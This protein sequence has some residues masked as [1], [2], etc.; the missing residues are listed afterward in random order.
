[1]KI[2]QINTTYNIGS[3][4]RIVSGLER[5]IENAGHQSVVAYGY[6]ER[7]D[8]EHFKIITKFDSYCHN[9][10]SRLTDSQ[11]LH[12]AGKTKNLIDYIKEQAPDIIHLH[13]LHG[14]YLNYPLLLEFL[15][16]YDSKIVWTLHDCWPFTGHCAYFDRI[17][18]MQWIKGCEKCPQHNSYPP[19]I[20]SCSR[21]NFLIKETLYKRLYN[22]M[23]IVPV[24]NWL[25]ALLQQSI[26]KHCNIKTVHNGIN[27][28]NFR[29]VESKLSNPPYVLGIAFPWDKR[30]GLSDFIRL[31]TI[32]NEKIKIVLVGLSQ[33]QIKQLPVGI[34]GFSR[35]SSLNELC[36]LYSGAIALINTTYED[37]YPTVN[38][39]SIACGTPVITYKTGGSP[40][41]ISDKTGAVVNKGD[42]YAIKKYAEDILNGD[43][44]FPTD[45]LVK[46]A[47][48]NFD[49]RECFNKYLDLYQSL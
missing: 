7:N 2:F 41:S 21:H 18:C 49:E 24:S 1:M 35:I 36:A 12:S 3:T 6:G 40:E 10:A 42:I 11:G 47:K 20:M 28:D 34:T 17:G 25:A 23:T 38:L 15:C 33:K 22:K 27:L 4:G 45:V 8:D 43:L 14:N 44:Q 46:E 26:L 30:K 29:P 31:R 13:N 37:N 16:D 5:V 39:E 48:Q 19:S 9:I 32:L